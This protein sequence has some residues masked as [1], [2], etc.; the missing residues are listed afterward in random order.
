MAQSLFP[1]GAALD[2]FCRRHHIRW[3]APFGSTLEGIARPDSDVDLQVIGEAFTASE[4]P[5]DRRGAK[6]RAP[7]QAALFSVKST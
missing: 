6:F 2:A 3:L 7:A 5:L 1:E 4:L